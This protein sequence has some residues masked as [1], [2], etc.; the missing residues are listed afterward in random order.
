L[1]WYKNRLNRFWQPLHPCCQSAPQSTPS[2]W[3]KFRAVSIFFC[4]LLLL[5]LTQPPPFSPPLPP[6]TSYPFISSSRRCLH[7]FL[8]LPLTFTIN[9]SPF[10]PSNPWEFVGDSFLSTSS[11]NSLTFVGISVVQSSDRGITLF[12]LVFTRS[13][14]FLII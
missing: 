14:S 9:Q 3:Q 11:I 5:T 6:F 1:N 8:S 4:A 12:L 7:F 13:H 2:V 10:V